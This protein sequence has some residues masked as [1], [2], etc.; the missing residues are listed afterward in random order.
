MR[1]EVIRL[2]KINFPETPRTSQMIPNIKKKYPVLPQ[3]FTQ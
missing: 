2:Q 3:T 1:I